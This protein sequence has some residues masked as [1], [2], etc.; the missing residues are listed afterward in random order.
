M[1]ND[2]IT[3]T[4]NDEPVVFVRK[5]SIPVSINSDS[6]PYQI[7]KAYHIRTVTMA[8]HGKL[9]AVT[10]SEIVLRDAAWIADSGRFSEYL[11]GKEPNEIEPFPSGDVIIGRGSIIDA[12]QRDG[13]FRKVK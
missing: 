9:V 8:L 6:G 5:D 10:P 7:G 12:F 11:D 3:L 1:K 2:E 4:I 13:S